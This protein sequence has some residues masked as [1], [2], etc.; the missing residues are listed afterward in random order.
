MNPA[1]V[2]WAL[3]GRM[4]S[5]VRKLGCSGSK[6]NKVDWTGHQKFATLNVIT[7]VGKL[8][9]GFLIW[10]MGP[11]RTGLVSIDSYNDM[12]TPTFGECHIFYNGRAE[13]ACISTMPLSVK[14]SC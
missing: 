9:V 5:Q 4:R 7:V 2:W 1:V 14:W 13:C 3:S 11:Q 10:K 6:P 8:A 12:I